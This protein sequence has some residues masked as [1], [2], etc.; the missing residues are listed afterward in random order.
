MVNPAGTVLWLVGITILDDRSVSG[1]EESC[2]PLSGT[3]TFALRFC[4]VE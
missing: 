1:D 4:E 2:L 3:R